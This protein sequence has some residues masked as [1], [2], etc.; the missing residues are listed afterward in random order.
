MRIACGKVWD[1]ENSKGY[2][3]EIEDGFELETKNF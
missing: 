2:Q 1:H 3:I